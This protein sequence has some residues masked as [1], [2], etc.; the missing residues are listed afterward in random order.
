M[1]ST[2]I[3]YLPDLQIPSQMRIFETASVEI[4]LIDRIT[5]PLE[6]NSVIAEVLNTL[7]ERIQKQKEGLIKDRLTEMGM[8]YLLNDLNVRR[9]KRILCEKMPGEETYWA[10]NGTIEGVRIITFKSP[11]PNNDYNNNS[12]GFELKYY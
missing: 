10:D 12:I 5:K 8:E 4:T 9:F 1:R 11:E 2:R 7:L 6:N 3:G